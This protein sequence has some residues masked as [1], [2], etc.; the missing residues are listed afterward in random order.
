M[1]PGAVKDISWEGSYKLATGDFGSVHKVTYS[2]EP[3]AF[4]LH[5]N[6]TRAQRSIDFMRTAGTH[7]NILP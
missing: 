3:A 5:T 6:H 7:P 4:K 2:E 1:K